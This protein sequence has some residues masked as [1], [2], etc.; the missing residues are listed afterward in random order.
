MK[1]ISRAAARPPSAKRVMAYKNIASKSSEASYNEAYLEPG[2]G[3]P[4]NHIKHWNAES[5]GAEPERCG[6]SGSPT[7]VQRVRNVVL[8]AGDVGQVPN[9]DEGIAGL[10]HELI[11][12]NIIG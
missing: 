9:T 5:I 3:V 2:A 12:E 1:L 10:I 4:L 7:K 6:L 11:E 8:T